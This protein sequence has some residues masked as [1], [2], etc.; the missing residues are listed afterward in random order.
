MEARAGRG[1]GE[2]ASSMSSRSRSP[3]SGSR[4]SCTPWPRPRASK[5]APWIS[6]PW[7]PCTPASACALISEHLLTSHQ[8]CFHLCVHGQCILEDSCA[9]VL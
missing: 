2:V 8:H 1:Q 6:C 5:S 7:L 4:R 9:C 3:W